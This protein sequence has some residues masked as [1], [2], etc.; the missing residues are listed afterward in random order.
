MVPTIVLP[1][2]LMS[3]PLTIF[4]PS[5]EI[6]LPLLIVVVWSISLAIFVPLNTP[7]RLCVSCE[8]YSCVSVA[9]PTFTSPAASRF[10][11]PV[12][13]LIVLPESVMSLPDTILTVPPPFNVVPVTLS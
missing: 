13:R 8:L 2:T 9:A 11:L 12:S 5:A 3:F 6:V 10:A 1:A 4:T 7:L